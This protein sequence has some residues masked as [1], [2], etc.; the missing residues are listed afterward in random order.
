MLQQLVRRDYIGIVLIRALRRHLLFIF[1][2]PPPSFFYT[3]FINTSSSS[4]STHT[5]SSSPSSS[6]TQQGTTPLSPRSILLGPT[7]RLF[8]VSKT[9]PLVVSGGRA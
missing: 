4:S 9:A 7:Q 1:S 8:I 5:P 3:L 2:P 6:S